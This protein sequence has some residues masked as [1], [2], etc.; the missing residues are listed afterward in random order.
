[1]IS[2]LMNSG[3]P[4]SCQAAGQQAW[5]PPT[6][7]VADQGGRVGADIWAEDGTGGGDGGRRAAPVRA[8]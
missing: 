3:F 8:S 2:A 5:S 1:M 4:L 7:V 6:Q